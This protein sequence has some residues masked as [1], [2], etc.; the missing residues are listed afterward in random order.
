MLSS[1]ILVTSLFHLYGWNLTSVL[2]L[3]FLPSWLFTCWIYCNV[4]F[5]FHIIVLNH[6]I[7]ESL[8][9]AFKG[10]LVQLSC[11][12]QGCTDQVAQSLAQPAL[13]CLYR[14]HKSERRQDFILQGKQLCI[15][16]QPSLSF[17]STLSVYPSKHINQGW[18][19]ICRGVPVLSTTCPTLVGRRTKLH[20]GATGF[21][22]IYLQK[23]WPLSD[24]PV[25]FLIL[26]L[27]K[28]GQY[29]ISHFYEVKF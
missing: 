17:N 1:V 4:F 22:F 8:T 16:E 20:H 3:L 13:E 29:L 9:G 24:L 23:K 10:Q 15:A 21:N 5:Q 26:H 7:T 19:Q 18:M 25:T 28:S 11:H 12:E 6:R 27:Y 2:C 14:T